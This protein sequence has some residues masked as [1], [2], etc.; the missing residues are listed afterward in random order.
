MS[1]YVTGEGSIP[2]LMQREDRQPAAHKC[3]TEHNRSIAT[4]NQNRAETKVSPTCSLTPANHH[5]HLTSC[6]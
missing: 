2:P 6:G 1:E 5:D 4:E 3:H